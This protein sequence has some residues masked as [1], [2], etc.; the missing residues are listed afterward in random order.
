MNSLRLRVPRLRVD[1][2]DASVR[3]CYRIIVVPNGVR[4]ALRTAPAA[5][6]PHAPFP[7]HSYASLVASA[8]STLPRMPSPPSLPVRDSAYFGEQL[9]ACAPSGYRWLPR[10]DRLCTSVAPAPIWD[11]QEQVLICLR[12]PQVTE[13]AFV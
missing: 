2:N 13:R 6:P 11:T 12:S 8:T 7:H 4:P 10:L 9:P 5:L 1:R 3:V